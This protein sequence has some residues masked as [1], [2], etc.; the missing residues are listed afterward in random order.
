MKAG[1][2]FAAMPAPAT[3]AEI[4]DVN[5]RYHDAAAGDYDAKWGIDFGPVGQRQVT[6]KLSKALG[7]RPG[8][9][10]RG[11]EI[12]AGTGYFTLNLMRAGV[13]GSG[14]CVDISPG[15]LDVL[16]DNAESLGLEVDTVVGDAERLRL[17]ST[18]FD[19]V[20]G[21]AVL[22]HL[23][24]L[25]RAFEE[26]HRLLRPGGW[27]VFAGEPSLHGDRLAR[28]PKR[29]AAALAPLWRAAMRAPAAIFGPAG[30][31]GA[32]GDYGMEF[33]VDVHAFSPGDLRELAASA[34]FE[35]VRVHGEELLAS[36]FGW[37]NRTLEGTARPDGVPW[38]WRQ[39]AY[40][41]YL[42]LQALDRH[43]LEGRLPPAVFYNL[44]VAARKPD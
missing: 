8:R 10:E 19:L 20:L 35:S 43:L 6:T 12:G 25:P 32:G 28:V 13:L 4:R 33:A 11:L 27:L 18:R 38:L 7:R 1:A 22:H 5:L 30:E 9:F 41:G 3:H 39:Y 36:W 17:P 40:R 15:M 29:G 31:D 44:M 21:H 34:G 16:R 2:R 14:V 23:P 37:A 26:F 42:V 24:D